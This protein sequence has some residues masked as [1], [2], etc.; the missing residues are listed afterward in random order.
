[1]EAA[2]AEQ[3]PGAG[4]EL[5]G[6][7]AGERA[8]ERVELGKQSDVGVDV[9]ARERLARSSAAVSDLAGGPV[10]VQQAG[11][12]GPRQAGRLGQKAVQQTLVGL[13]PQGVLEP[14]Y[15]L[16]HERVGVGPGF[17]VEGR[18]P[19][20]RRGIPEPDPGSAGGACRVSRSSSDDPRLDAPSGS[21]VVGNKPPVQAHLSLEETNGCPVGACMIMS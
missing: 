6:G 9:A 19:G 4:A 12:L 13:R 14:L 3:M 16:H 18:S 7:G 11:D 5:A 17:A 2:V 10:P 21:S 1:M 15:G 20:S 8:V